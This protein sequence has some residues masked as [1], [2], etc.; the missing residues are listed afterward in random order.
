MR[1]YLVFSAVFLPNSLRVVKAFTGDL[2]LTARANFTTKWLRR[3]PVRLGV[4][5][6]FGFPMGFLIYNWGYYTL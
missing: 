6:F 2:A 1:D 4:V 3:L 5:R